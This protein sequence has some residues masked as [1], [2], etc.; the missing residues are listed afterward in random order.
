MNLPILVCTMSVVILSVAVWNAKPAPAP[1]A[2]IQ[3]VYQWNGVSRE[4]GV[5]HRDKETGLLVCSRDT[6]GAGPYLG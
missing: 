5:L 3:E 4:F 6:G 1:A 2:C